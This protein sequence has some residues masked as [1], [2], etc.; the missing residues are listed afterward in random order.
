MNSMMKKLTA[1]LLAMAMCLSMLT[2]CG[3]KK[4]STPD[5][6]VS[7]PDTS[8]VSSAETSE[9]QET[10]PDASA[11][12]SQGETSEIGAEGET[13]EAE[14]IGAPADAPYDYTVKMD[15]TNVDFSALS[16]LDNEAIPYGF[17]TKNR[18]SLNRPDGIYYYDNL[19]GEYGGV[20]HINTEDKLVYLTMD[21]GYE[22][23]CTPE[24]LDT[25]KDKGVKAV[26]FITKQFYDEHPELIQRMIDEGHI[27]G[28]HTCKHPAGGMPQLGAQ[29]EY[30]D[31]KWL[32]DA[33]YDTFGY[34]MRL[35]RFP[36]GVASKQS[37]ALL[38]M[39]GYRSI[40]WSFAYRDYD[41]ENQMDTSEALSATLD[42]VHPGAV[43][44]L[45]A[46]STTNTAIL[47]DWIDGCRAKGYEFG[48]FP[49]E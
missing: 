33:V 22:N 43:Y 45:H 38:N 25:L 8:A 44:L 20:T 15:V 41:T 35:F 12:T 16:A 24:I 11:E 39:M 32:N 6:S 46:V 23:G 3:K 4:D 19:Y 17:S 31:I 30:E 42:Q 27:V 47:G 14:A 2:A 40:F 26:F 36:E 18:D 28:N 29:D 21:E 1:L 5:A 37:V 9:G 34:Q 7:Q 48:V 13:E 49:V 10:A